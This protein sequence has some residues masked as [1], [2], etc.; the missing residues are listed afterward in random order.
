M[1]NYAKYIKSKEWK[2][3]SKKF[4]DSVGCCEKCN[5]TKKLGCHHITYDNLG[6]ETIKDIKVWCW[7]C[8]KQHHINCGDCG[9]YEEDGY[10]IKTKKKRYIMKKARLYKNFSNKDKT[11]NSNEYKRER[12]KHNEMILERE[13]NSFNELSKRNKERVK[14][15]NK[16]MNKPKKKEVNK[17]K[18]KREREAL[19]KEIIE[20]EKK[21][22]IEEL[23]LKLRNNSN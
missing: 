17:H 22:K 21:A 14:P 20:N 2:E 3:K 4:I 8:H 10:K 19:W 12:I 6:N 18:Q 7:P 15:R 13:K 9:D 23:R 16:R 11:S 5:S 1:V